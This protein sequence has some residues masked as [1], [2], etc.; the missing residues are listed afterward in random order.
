M[1]KKKEL[2]DEV[3]DV[4]SQMME[5]RA[6]M[7]KVCDN[8]GLDFNGIKE[9][10]GVKYIDLTDKQ[11][12]VRIMGKKKEETDSMAF[13]DCTFKITTANEIMLSALS[14]YAMMLDYVTDSKGEDTLNVE[15]V[16]NNILY[17]GMSR[18]MKDLVKRHG[19]ESSEDFID[20]MRGCQCGEEVLNEIKHHECVEYQRLHDDILAHIP[21]EDKQTKFDFAK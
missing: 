6:Q 14:K 8:A 5:L 19:F 3:M 11:N 20:S 16:I 1:G 15:G 21:V 2:K 17:N 13:G 18:M 7:R 10:N 12:G 4:Q 9:E